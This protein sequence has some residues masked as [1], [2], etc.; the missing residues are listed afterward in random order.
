MSYDSTTGITSITGAAAGTY[1]L[2]VKYDPTVLV[3]Y[4]PT[5]TLVQIYMFQTSVG[6]ILKPESG[7]TLNLVKK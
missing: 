1:F 7:A 3:G 4:A 2:S 5:G 6:G